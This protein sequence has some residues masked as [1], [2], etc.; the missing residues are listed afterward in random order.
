MDEYIKLAEEVE[1]RAIAPK[2]SDRGS[3]TD[4]L[5]VMLKEANDNVDVKYINS[6]VDGMLDAIERL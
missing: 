4:I 3:V 2:P 1:R 5:S 6:L